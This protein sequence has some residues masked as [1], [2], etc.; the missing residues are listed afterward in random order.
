MK[1][2]IFEKL[3]VELSSLPVDSEPR[4]IYLLVQIRKLL[5]HAE[6]NSSPLR[7]YCNWAVHIRLDHSS[8]Q[9]MLRKLENMTEAQLIKFISLRN[10][11][12]ELGE[13]LIQHNLPTNLTDIES[14]WVKFQ[15]SLINILIDVPIQY[16]VPPSTTYFSFQ[17]RQDS[18]LERD[19][20]QYHMVKNGKRILGNVY[21]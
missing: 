16:P 15:D 12:S 6:N 8:A 18:P 10:L 5:D 19:C 13:F 17:R 2:E 7:F 14:N 1:S 3:N 4:A 9:R 11:R 21:R 20:I